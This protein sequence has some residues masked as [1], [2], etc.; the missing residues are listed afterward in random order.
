VS[1]TQ[2]YAHLDVEPLRELV[3]MVGAAVEDADE[4]AGK[5]LTKL[6]PQSR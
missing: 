6:R 5:K 1:T 3:N 2:R 4:V